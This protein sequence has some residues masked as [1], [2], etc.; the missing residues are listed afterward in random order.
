MVWLQ[1]LTSALLIVI[2]GVKLVK[3]TDILSD[4]LSLSKAW[5]GVILLGLVTS[6]PEAITSITALIS[7]Q[8]TDLAV[9]NMLG[10]NLFNLMIIVLLDA[11]YRKGSVTDAIEPNAANILPAVFAILLS[12]IVGTEIF[13]GSKM[14]LPRIGFMSYGLLAVAV[15][16]LVG[17]RILGKIGAIGSLSGPVSSAG[18][19]SPIL[20]KVILV[21]SLNA[22]LV[23]VASIGLT[24]SCETIAHLTNLGRTFIG[25]TLLAW[26]TS[27]PEIVVSVSAFRIGSFDMAFGNIFG[28]NM[29]NMFI[30]FICS[31]FYRKGPILAA[32]SQTHVFSAMAVIMISC[33]ALAGIFS[34]NKKKYAHM[35]IDSITM[36]IFFVVIIAVLYRLK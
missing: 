29:V 13:I 27:L 26:S 3:Y 12:M 17:I 25:S 14:T 21:L 5:L 11:M 10:S 4:K 9:G 34:K 7:F 36:S 24:D 32:V 20:S 16:Y 28:S 18:K 35:G 19:N 30:V 2:A 6:L 22:V 15:I 23:I 33:L 31:F 8:A 1:F